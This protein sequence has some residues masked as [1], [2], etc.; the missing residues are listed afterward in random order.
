[1]CNLYSMTRTPE[2]VRRLF[3]IAH[4]HSAQLSAERQSINLSFVAL[5]YRIAVFR[6]GLG[7]A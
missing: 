2:A 4:N 5:E 1:M 6:R 3:R 7:S